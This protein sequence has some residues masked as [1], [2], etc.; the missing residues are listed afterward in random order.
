MVRLKKEQEGEPTPQASVDTGS[1]VIQ[2]VDRAL[3]IL[4]LIAAAGGVETL[5]NISSISGLNI[6]TCHHL[7]STLSR[8]KYVVR[9]AGRGA[10]AL[11]PQIQ[12][13]ASAF[14]ADADLLRRA[15]PW[16]EKINEVTGETVH[17]ATL[18]GDDLV[19]LVKRDAR[20]AVRVDSG[21]LGKSDA[22]H[23]TATGKAILAWLDEAEVNRILQ[24]KGMKAYTPKTITN[25]IMLFEE[26]R[27]IRKVGYSMDR[28]EFQPHVVCVGAAIVGNDGVVLGSISASTPIMRADTDH[29]AL[30]RLE[31]MNA[32]RA[33]SQEPQESGNA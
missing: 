30:M 16:I 14:N 3:A 5:N 31:V 21:M 1:T 19:T 24:A 33:L 2:S 6:S 4:E 18:Q 10:Y 26:L 13:L 12:M 25:P 28:E 17:L 9:A 22:S 20:H 7:I 32:A 23:A 8:R 15:E 11:G 29:L 27:S